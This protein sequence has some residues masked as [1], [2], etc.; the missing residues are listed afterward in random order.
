MLVLPFCAIAAMR[1]AEVSEVGVLTSAVARTRPFVVTEPVISVAA[2]SLGFLVTW[3]MT[4]PVEPRPNNMDDGPIN[5][6]TESRANR[7]R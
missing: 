1:K 6:S 2:L 4:P 3:L 7:S 5:T